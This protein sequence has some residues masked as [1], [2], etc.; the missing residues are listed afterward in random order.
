MFKNTIVFALVS[1]LFSFAY[2]QKYTLSGYVKDSAS[3]E[4]INGAIITALNTAESTTTN[5]YG[6]FS[7]T[8][9]S[10]KQEFRVSASGYEATTETI[11]LSKNVDVVF[12]LL[13][14]IETFDEIN[15][16]AKRNDNIKKIDISTQSITGKVIKKIPAF[17]GEADVIKSI[18][19]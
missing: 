13:S 1:C 6:F 10:K 17:L 3:G 14:T 2:G 19:L 12:S 4:S 8:V 11:D 7:L 18:Q 5:S 16:R 15:I 9:K